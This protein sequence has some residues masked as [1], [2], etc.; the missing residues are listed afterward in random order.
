[1]LSR[2]ELEKVARINKL[3]LYQQEKEYL[4]FILLN[5]ISSRE[6]F[7]FKGGTA[8]RLAYSHVRF[9]EDLD[10]NC[11][12]KPPEIKKTIHQILNNFS[13]L[14]IKYHFIKEELFEKSY[15]SSIRFK[16]PLYQERPDSTN[17]FR[18]DIS[19]QP[20]YLTEVIKIGQRFPEIPAFYLKC[21]AKKQIFAEKIR[22]L[23]QRTK[24]R[25]LFDVFALSKEIK[26]DKKML[27]KVLG[28]KTFFHPNICSKKDFERDMNRLVKVYP[29]YQEV[30]KK[31]KELSKEVNKILKE[32]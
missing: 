10:F 28:R 9:S 4:M 5:G 15:T 7:I 11:L 8:L 17:S 23:S 27:K 3:D 26:P 29:P 19:N 30:V 21:M 32:K 16:G 25:D 13:L 1:M 24:P 20:T 12:L 18:L 31:V 22:T 14:G 2:K 6:E